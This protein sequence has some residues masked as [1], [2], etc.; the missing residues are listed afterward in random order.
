M[1][2]GGYYQL[3]DSQFS[4]VAHVDASLGR[5]VRRYG[6]DS[7]G[8][9]TSLA[10]ADIDGDGKVGGT[11][12]DDLMLAG[13]SAQPGDPRADFNGDGK[14]NGD[15]LFDYEARRDA[16]PPEEGGS[17]ACG[18]L[19]WGDV[20][21]PRIGYAGYIRPEWTAP[22]G[23][24]GGGGGVVGVGWW[25][26]RHRFYD[27]VAGRWINRDPAGYVD[28][29]SMYL[30]VK[31]NP[32]GLVD[33]M[34]LRGDE[35]I[36]AGNGTTRTYAVG[37]EGTGAQRTFVE[38]TTVV[39]TSLMQALTFGLLG[40]PS[41]TTTTA[42]YRWD[43]SIPSTGLTA[44]EC[45]VASDTG[46]LPAGASE[47][48]VEA[49]S[50]Q[51]R[52]VD[53][54]LGELHEAVQGEVASVVLSMVAPVGKGLAGLGKGTGAL[55]VA[56]GTNRAVKTGEFLPFT[57]GNFRKNAEIAFG[58]K[59]LEGKSA[60]HLVAHGDNR[61]VISRQILD[62][63]GINLHDPRHNGAALGPVHNNMHTNEY[64]EHMEKNLRESRTREDALKF[65][66]DTRNILRNTEKRDDLPWQK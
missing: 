59:A 11:E 27:P 57:K 4:V 65:L 33:P 25:L 3:A 64:Y 50:A 38:T 36:S 17:P 28:G 30:Y 61:A 51:R 12:D 54:G 43:E 49:V 23:G 31:G 13:T 16:T 37:G 56:L 45:I 55:P 32:F 48:F 5:V 53:T 34:G 1:T 7:H 22:G 9:L 39:R 2:D 52:V 41:V 58:K 20:V 60:H 19:G 35:P 63:H 40:S 29:L 46:K 47:A 62:D 26:A 18:P 21:E 8:G 44:G 6:Y 42:S 15:D 14:T 24:G 66:D 10:L